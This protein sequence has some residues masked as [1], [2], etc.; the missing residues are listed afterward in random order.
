MTQGLVTAVEQLV[1]MVVLSWFIWWFM[2]V[3]GGFIVVNMMV[4]G[5]F[6][7]GL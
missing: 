5:D 7:D 1:F 2:V 6:C 4:Y 3:Y